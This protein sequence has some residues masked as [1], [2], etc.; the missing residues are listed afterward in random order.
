MQNKL[1]S[2]VLAPDTSFR[3]FPWS[4][5]RFLC[6]GKKFAQVELVAALAVLFRRHRVQPQCMENENLGQAQDRIFR[7]I[8]DIEHEGKILH[9]RGTLRVRASCGTN[10]KDEIGFHTPLKHCCNVR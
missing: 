6:P 7:A 9:E 3:F 10:V 8:L 2:E 5:G 1:E 4:D